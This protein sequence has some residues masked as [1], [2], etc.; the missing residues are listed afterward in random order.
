MLMFQKASHLSNGYL[1]KKEEE[2]YECNSHLNSS[3]KK[4]IVNIW[5]ACPPFH[6]LTFSV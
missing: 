1:N 5:L 2:V 4:R 6:L 3:G